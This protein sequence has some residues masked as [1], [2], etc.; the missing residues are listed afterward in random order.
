MFM[1]AG[2]AAFPCTRMRERLKLVAQV[3]TYIALFRRLYHS[4]AVFD[5][6]C[7]GLS[8]WTTATAAREG[9]LIVVVRGKE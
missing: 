8:G 1:F 9:H 6:G 7:R 4:Y 2:V 3:K 5:P